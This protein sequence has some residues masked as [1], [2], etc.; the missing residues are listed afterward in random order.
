MTYK[1]VIIGGKHS[2]QE[3]QIENLT[4]AIEAPGFLDSGEFALFT[5]YRQ[6]TVTPV[7]DSGTVFY[8]PER[9]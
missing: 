2:G 8:G 5:Y 3:F 4:G 6:P 1:A 9:R 7:K